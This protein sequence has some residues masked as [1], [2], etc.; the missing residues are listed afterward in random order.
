LQ[1]FTYQSACSCFQFS[2]APRAEVWGLESQVQLALDDHFSLRAAV[3]YT[4]ARYR[5]FMGEAPTGAPYVPPIYGY[6]TGPTNFA[7][8]SMIR[9]PDWT[10]DAGVTWHTPSDI[11]TWNVAANLSLTSTVPFTPDRQ[12]T[13]GGYGLL[14]LSAGWTAPDGAWSASVSGENVTDRRYQIFSAEGFLGHSIIYGAPASWRL[15]VARN[16]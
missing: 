13:Q 9:S 15:Q 12:L 14:N 11:G 10:G 2:N 16:F 1:T 4:H 5:D 8:D 3:A 6:A 7:G